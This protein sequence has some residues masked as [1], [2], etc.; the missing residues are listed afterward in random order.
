MVLRPFARRPQSQRSRLLP[1]SMV[2]GTGVMA[3]LL[4]ITDSRASGADKE[5]PGVSAVNATEAELETK[6]QKLISELGAAQY[7]TR[8][9]AQSEL[10]RL[11]LT[12]FDALYEAQ[13]HEDIEISLR[14]Q[15][16]VRSLTVDWAHEDDPVEVKRILRGYGEKK[17]NE[18]KTLMDQLSRLADGV[19]VP[20]LARLAR[21]ERSPV[22]SKQAALLIMGQSLPSDDEKR[23]RL[24]RQIEKAMEL[25]KRPAAKWLRT[26]S[27]TLK[28]PAAALEE[29]DRVVAD[30]QRTLEEFPGAT[31]ERL[32]LELLRWQAEF[33]LKLDRRS[34]AEETMRRAAA[35]V[36]GSRDQII[37]TVDWLMTHEAWA[38]VDEIA[39]RFQD[40]FQT[41]AVLMYRLAEAQLKRGQAERAEETARRAFSLPNENMMER[42]ECAYRLHQSRGLID[43]AEREYRYVLEQEPLVSATALRA[44]QRLAEMLHDFERD[45]EAAR[46]YQPL[47]DAMDRDQSVE[48][49]V[50]QAQFDPAGIRSRMHYLFAEH[51]R[52]HGDHARQRTSLEQALQHDPTE[53]DALI[54]MYR[55]PGGDEAARQKIHRMIEEAAAKFREDL[56]QHRKNLER[57]IGNDVIRGRVEHLLAIYENQYAW[58]VS[59]TFGDF[60]EALRLSQESLRLRP[61]TGAYLD[62]LAHCYY[63]VGDLENAVKYQAQAVEQ[64][65]HSGQIARKLAFFQRELEAS[66]K[67]PSK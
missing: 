36:K 12:A 25:S 65:P 32:V 34:E 26:Y 45:M 44:R 39:A 38:L 59:N 46:V 47:C 33:L 16:L 22:L 9:R 41:D 11:G 37:E 54:A 60:Q 67:K 5:T 57:T 3:A 20:A 40:M 50:M 23:E 17:E 24:V 8:E 21:F 7:A 53:A 10:K 13:N 64:E 52:R 51:Y 18:R 2:L 42:Y 31:S 66:K 29:W 48:R 28:D 62:T 63:A 55:A 35:L 27:R 1:L 43:W 49:S 14:A 19:G 4:I 56:Q 61:N 30:E 15:F 6:I 58:L